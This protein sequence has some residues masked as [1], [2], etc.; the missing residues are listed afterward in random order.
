MKR[1][2]VLCLAL[3]VLL[4]AGCQNLLGTGVPVRAAAI[5]PSTGSGRLSIQLISEAPTQLAVNVG[6]ERGGK[7]LVNKI[8][9][10]PAGGMLEIGWED[11]YQFQSGDRI[12]LMHPNYR[13]VRIDIP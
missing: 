5:R 7:L 10:I 13:T 9:A 3:T 1:M 11:G 2:V 12:V 6:L 4:Q 8:V